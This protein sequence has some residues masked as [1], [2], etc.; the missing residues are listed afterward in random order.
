MYTDLN[1][2]VAVVTGASKGI[3]KAIA[4]RLAQEHMKLVFNYHS[5]QN[6]AQVAVDQ[7]KQNGGD[8]V[9]VQAD[10]S[11]EEDVNKLVKTAEEEF[12]GL[13][14]FINNAGMEKEVPTH[15]LELKDWQRVIDVNLTGTFLGTKAA[16]NYFLDH[17]QAGNIINMSSVHQ[18]ISWPHFADYSASKGGS[19][20]FTETVAKEYAPNNIRV[21]SIAPGAIN[22]PINAK[23]FADPKAYADTA[24]L[25]P[26]NRIGKPEEVAAAAAWLASSESSYVTGETIYVD[27]GMKLYPEFKEGRG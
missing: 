6:G 24:E 5:D 12:G 20:L 2:K 1:G 11:K 22:T 15:K 9:A 27:G 25:V 8:A 3:G 14:L 10:V 18:T 19:K 26:M 17:N 21:N 23:K 16:L 4:L 13:D 7:I